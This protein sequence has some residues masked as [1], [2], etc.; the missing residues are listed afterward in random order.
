MTG[1]GGLS[2]AEDSLG[3]TQAIARLAFA[4]SRFAVT[5]AEANATSFGL[6]W[7][8]HHG[9]TSLLVR[10]SVQAGPWR[11][12]GAVGQ[13][14]TLRADEL[15]QRFDL[16][17][18]SQVINVGA[19]GG[20]GPLTGTVTLQRART[21][22]W[23]LMEASGIILKRV[24][25]WYGLHDA[26]VEVAWQSRRVAF[27]ASRSWRAGFGDTQGTSSGYGWSAMWR[28]SAPLQFVVHGGKQ[29]AE[30]LRG[31]PEAHYA[32]IVARVQ[33]SRSVRVP[34]TLA[35]ASSARDAEFVLL[36]RAGGAD[37]VIRIDAPRDAVVEV[38]TSA[39]DWT[40]A[41]LV[42]D[43]ERFALRVALASG[44]HRVAVRVNGGA[45]RAP[46]GLTRVD[47]EFGG[48]A[49]IVVVP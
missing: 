1:E 16:S 6:A 4:P 25:P 42:H 28:A 31:V 5:D 2:L 23:Q 32:G 7:P 43:G 27:T 45:W 9:N 46:R 8:G 26:E 15:T 41:R 22:D 48:A 14:R 29:M 21:D 19:S 17:M 37:V 40:P 13:G 11:V 12:F 24:A 34:S 49:G 20:R 30:P 33:R 38:A 39:T 35:V 10:Q 44:A 47:D 3:A 36:P 18:R